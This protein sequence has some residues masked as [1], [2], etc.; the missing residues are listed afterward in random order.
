[1]PSGSADDNVADEEACRARLGEHYAF[2]SAQRLAQ[3]NLEEACFNSNGLKWYMKIDKMDMHAINLPT[4]WNQLATPFFK[5]GARILCAVNGSHWVGAL[6]S[7]EWHIR[8]L[9]EDI[10]HGSEMQLSTIL[11]NLGS[12]ADRE[13]HLPDEFVVGSDNTP[14]EMNI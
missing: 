5:G 9:F 13:G 10:S 14:K 8:T 1:M 6:R 3:D 2:Q 12:I 11:L 7:P 4:I